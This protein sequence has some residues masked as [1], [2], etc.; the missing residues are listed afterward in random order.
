MGPALG[1]RLDVEILMVET[2]EQTE[3]SEAQS[4]RNMVCFGLLWFAMV[5]KQP[6]VGRII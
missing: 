2:V 5:S 6:T 4:C 1:A 3:E